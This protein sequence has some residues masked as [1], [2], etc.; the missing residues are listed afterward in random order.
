[1]VTGCCRLVFGNSCATKITVALECRGP[2]RVGISFEFDATKEYSDVIRVINRRFDRRD[3]EDTVEQK[4]L[5]R[6]LWRSA[7]AT[8]RECLP[9]SFEP[10]LDAAKAY[11]SFP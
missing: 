3:G 9:W 4:Q 2:A 6:Q 10:Y 7:L 11:I 8:W 5:H 1:M